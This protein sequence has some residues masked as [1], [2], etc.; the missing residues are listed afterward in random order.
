MKPEQPTRACTHYQTLCWYSGGEINGSE[1]AVTPG[2]V[3]LTSGRLDLHLVLTL[4]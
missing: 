1:P 2:E 3:R 4:S